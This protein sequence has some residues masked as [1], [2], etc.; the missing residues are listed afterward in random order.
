ME[1]VAEAA[2]IGE[3]AAVSLETEIIGEDVEEDCW[4][5]DW[6]GRSFATV[7]AFLARFLRAAANEDVLSALVPARLFNNY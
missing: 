2:T 5:V 1:A 6:G 7:L 3:A 4:E